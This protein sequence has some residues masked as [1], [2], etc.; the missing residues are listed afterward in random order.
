[1]AES[2]PVGEPPLV[3]FAFNRPHKLRRVLKALQGQGVTRLLIFVDGPRGQADRRGVL[4]CQALARSVT[5]TE[6]ELYFSQQNRGLDSLSHNVS[7]VM[8]RYPAAIFVEDDCLPVPGFYEFMRRAL[9]RYADEQRV[10][11]IG[12][13]QHLPPAFFR[14]YPCSLVSGARFSCWGWATWRD[15]WQAAWPHIQDYASLFDNL[16]RMPEIAGRDVPLAV[17][18]MQAGRAATSWDMPVALAAIWLKKVHLLP[19]EGIVRTIGLD[20]SG[21][22][23]S[24]TNLLRALLLHNRNVARRA[25][26][27]ISWLEDVA[28]DCNYIAGMRDFVARAQ[29]ISLRRRAERGRVLFRRY[30]W[31]RREVLRDLTTEEAGKPQKRALLSYI[32]HPFF[33]PEDDRRFVNHTN[34]WHARAIVQVLNR[35]GYAVDVIDYRD[36]GELPRQE[37]DLFIGHGGANFERICRALPPATPRLLFTTGSY[38]RYH[39]QQEQERFAALEQRRGVRLPFDRYIRQDEDV[40]LRLADGVIGLGDQTTR[41]TYAGF[42]RVV[43]IDGTALYDDHLDWCPKDFNDSRA[44]FLFYSGPGNVHKGLDLLLEA[45]SGQEQ[46][47]WIST[48]LDARF[49]HLYRG[50]LNELANIHL[51]GWV[52][53]RSRGFYQMMHRCAFCILPSCSEGQSQSVI[54]AM[55]QGLI[56]LVSRQAGL[57]VRDSGVILEPVSVESIRA[58]VQSASAWTPERC[59]EM[60]AR[61]R[62]TALTVY[63]QEAFLRNFQSALEDLLS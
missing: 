23:G 26:Q 36:P 47:L 60:S 51:L 56:P 6:T 22:H 4:A 54:E 57:D 34:I 50:E 10:F 38:W 5:W 11:S 2:L 45:F 37:Y 46:H 33:I 28:P 59:A 27:D 49:A 21:M 55:N 16:T 62:H 13:Y 42:D 63:S 1:M 53:P 48:R 35:L 61:A 31:P 52:Q 30:V 25:P 9:A 20:L 44:H 14:G 19:V 24:L 40:A 41:Q 8:E 3:V 17:G 15:R 39:N 7:Q 12:G 58:L 43:T 18:E 32:V 29:A